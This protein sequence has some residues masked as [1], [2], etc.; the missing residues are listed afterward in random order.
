MVKRSHELVAL[1]LGLLGALGLGLLG[2]LAGAAQVTA[3]S[4]ASF[5]QPISELSTSGQ[6]ISQQST[7]SAPTLPASVSA[8]VDLALLDPSVQQQFEE[9]SS[10]LLRLLARERRDSAATA[11]AYGDLGQWFQVYD[12]LE[13]A[14]HCYRSAQELAPEDPRWPYYLGHVERDLGQLESARASLT[15]ALELR[16]QDV[17]TLVWLAE[18]ELE[19]GNGDRALELLERA[20][21]LSP[22]SPRVH[23]Q[24]GE[25]LLQRDQQQRAAEHLERALHLQPA[26]ASV[27]YSLGLAHRALGDLERA[28]THLEAA[29]V[30]ERTRMEP[31]LDDP[32]REQLQR[33]KEGSKQRSGRAQFLFSQGRFE[34]AAL[35]FRRALA[36]NP[37]SRTI[38]ANL[39]LALLRSG[40]ID[41]AIAM[42][43]EL[44]EQHDSFAGGHYNLG[45]ALQQAGQL[46]D[47]M[48]A[49]RTSQRLDPGMVE[50]Y[51]AL[52][53]LLIVEERHDEALG[54]FDRA[55][56]LEPANEAIRYRQAVLLIALERYVEA[57]AKLER[58]LAV[59]ADSRPLALLHARLLVAAPE[60]GVRDAQR[61][62][63]LTRRAALE[64]PSVFALETL[65]MVHAERGRLEQAVAL[66]ERALSAVS[67]GG[68]RAALE[69]VAG[70]LAL[71]RRGQPCRQPLVPGERML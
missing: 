47:A 12:Y 13:R 38:W 21:G 14:R 17:P 7:S 62:E 15:R 22:S 41:E 19:A 39:G 29:Q 27:H 37:E 64:P 32:L 53:T 34:E 58:G 40:Q 51:A 4:G 69:R 35:E 31:R 3:S 55:L 42:L 2:A 28:A 43:S 24:L 50:S 46:A 56:E 54:Q 52:G 48:R 9:R 71:Y 30:D 1:G 23:A 10:A 68:G 16:P 25:L 20:L 11:S 6:S 66:Q 44:A 61:A 49:Y 59:L 33:L 18:L 67:E 8:P 70:R 60:P 63:Q 57:A 26:A 65:A 45:V 5:F 36:D